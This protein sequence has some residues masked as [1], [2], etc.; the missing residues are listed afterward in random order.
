MRCSG[1]K[2]AAWKVVVAT[3]TRAAASKGGTARRLGRVD[4][5]ARC[6]GETRR[7]RLGVERKP[8]SDKTA[9]HTCMHSGTALSSGVGSGIGGCSSSVVCKASAAAAQRAGS[10]GAACM[11]GSAEVAG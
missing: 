7:Q 3:S 2:T 11:Y 1:V 10:R 5:G 8:A 6:G 9:V 4:S